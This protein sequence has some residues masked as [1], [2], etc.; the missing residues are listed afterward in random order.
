[1]RTQHAAPL[2]CASRWAQD[3]DDL[4]CSTVWKHYDERPTDDFGGEYFD[5]NWRVVE[6]QII[7][8]GVRM[9]AWLD[10]FVRDCGRKERVE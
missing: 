9:A 7:K 1:V 8:A 3:S 6:R 10:H 4:N 5:R 2:E